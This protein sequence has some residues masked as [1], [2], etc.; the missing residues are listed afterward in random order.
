[1]GKRIFA[2]II[3]L[4]FT[5]LSSCARY[6]DMGIEYPENDLGEETEAAGLDFWEIISGGEI[7]PYKLNYIDLYEGTLYGI[8]SSEHVI[9]FTYNFDYDNV[10]F[11]SEYPFVSKEAINTKFAGTGDF[12]ERGVEIFDILDNHDGP[13]EIINSYKSISWAG[14]S[15]GE[16]LGPLWIYYNSEDGY[17]PYQDHI[18]D[19]DKD[20]IIPDDCDFSIGEDLQGNNLLFIKHNALSNKIDVYEQDPAGTNIFRYKSEHEF[21]HRPIF[22]EFTQVSLADSSKTADFMFYIPKSWEDKLRASRRYI[23]GDQLFDEELLLDVYI[24]DIRGVTHNIKDIPNF[25]FKDFTVGDLN[26]DGFPEIVFLRPEGLIVGEI[27]RAPFEEYFAEQAANEPEDVVY[28]VGP[29]A[30]IEDDIN[31]VTG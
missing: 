29:S 14:K 4:I 5:M 13:E 1:M 16:K 18:K 19:A 8:V 2:I 20:I 7:I 6:P 15:Y 28:D 17:Q 22:F 12:V 3:T 26:N 11:K 10:K 24:Y 31:I 9:V 25:R 27:E 23:G 21:E 30:E